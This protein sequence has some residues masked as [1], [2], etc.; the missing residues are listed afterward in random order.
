[1]RRR[2]ERCARV[3]LVVAAIA[4]LGGCAVGP[5]YKR[6]PVITPEA[7][8]E[9]EGWKVAE[10][11]DLARRGAWWEMFAD[12][13][14]NELE[15]RV[16]A[17]NQ[18]LVAAAANYRQATALV[19]EARAGFFP[20]VTIGAGYTRSQVSSTLTSSGSN[21]N[22]TAGSLTGGVSSTTGRPT[23]FF[24]MPIDVTW[25]PDFWGRVRRTVES[26]QAAAQASAGDLETA[27]LS[28]QA[29]LAQDYFQM[30]TLDAQRK[31][32]DETVTAFEQSLELTRTR[33]RGGVASQVDIVQA[34]T[35]L[36]TTR[37]Q[38]I[39]VGVARAQF[40]HAIAVITGQAA[41]TF[42]LPMAP[43]TAP[44]PSVP[45]GVPSQLL[46]RRPDIAAAERRMASANAQIGVALAAYY[47]TITLSGS[48][49]F[50][51]S[52]IA[53][54][55]TWP[56]RFFAVGP[57]ITQTL[58]DGGLRHA[59]TDQARAAYDNSVAN[60]RE[61]VLTAFQGVEDNLAAL[62]ILESEADVQE[63]AVRAARRSVT[64][65]TSQYRAGI[66][67]Y[68]NVITTQTIALGN[69][70]TA[71]QIL[72]R[73]M[74]STVLLIQALGGGWNQAELPSAAAVTERTRER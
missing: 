17:A 29:E 72:G 13:T 42:T 7:Y 57:A 27:R 55:F 44:P 50:E 73:R 48:A 12:P 39:D 64:L 40:E 43:L 20:T 63:R 60:Y 19:R 21:A 54:W 49:G 37:A 1:M 25:T 15:S 34:E 28:L 23:N 53:Q 22:A 18:T 32:L 74:T 68:L 33:F 24:Q 3:A 11:G 16:S 71:V 38:A 52:S 70:V 56:S 26:N 4:A 35:Q 66:V 9:I 67:S 31:L 58:I 51:S 62:R 41:S 47:P 46:E 45:I 14:L 65:T 30:R 10:P 5:N 2:H 8:K 61:T 6:P 59:Q 36:E 69:E